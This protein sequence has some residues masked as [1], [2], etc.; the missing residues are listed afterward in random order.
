MFNVRQMSADDFPFA[1]ELANTMDWNMAVEDFEFS[2]WL[3]PFGCFVAVHGSKRIAIATCVS[4]GKVGWFGNLVVKEEFRS[5]GVG[6]LLV[7]HA[8][9][10]LQNKG[11][12]TIGLYAYQNLLDFYDNFGFK[13]G[14]DFSVLKI[15]SLGTSTYEKKPKI[16]NEIIGEIERFDAEFF[17]ANRSRLL[18]S[19]I[20]EKGNLGYYSSN[21]N[22]ILGYVASTV[23]DKMA[24]V[25]PLVFRKG[26]SDL[27]ASLVKAV[28]AKLRGQMVYLVPS[29]K[30]T[31]LLNMLL[32][33][34]FEEDFSVSRMFLG[35]PVANNCIYMPESLERG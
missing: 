15:N 32:G 2:S 7:K 26:Y 31:A 11:V 35:Q 34:G 18:E 5:Q 23:Y 4:Y 24:W 17:G 12:E 8:V 10:Y 6:S 27:A 30:E 20:F 14:E 28:L 33:L 1:T 3:D 13:C 16:V 25:G 29:K 19:I 9:D 21:S 22:G